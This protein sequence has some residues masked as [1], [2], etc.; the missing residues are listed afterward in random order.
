MKAKP[1]KAHSGRPP[2]FHEPR[3]PVTMILPTRI[4]DALATID[5]DRARAVVKVTEAVAGTDKKHS[6]P[7]ELVEMARNCFVIVVGPSE[8]LKRISSLKLIEI[9]PARYLLSISSG[10]PIEA[11][12]VALRDLLHDS[13]L[14]A[15]EPEIRIV[16][17]LLNLIGERRRTQRLTKSEILIIGGV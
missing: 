9:A 10:T 8:W 4:L 2:K 17:D 13:K 15:D 11:L 5:S 7:V 1:M 6:E 16:H 12:E 3:Q 14:Q